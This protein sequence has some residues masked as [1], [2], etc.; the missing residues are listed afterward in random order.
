MARDPIAGPE[1][2]PVSPFPIQLSGK[3]IK[4]FGRG[5][6]E[7]GIPTAN[8]PIEGLDV[9]G[10][11]DVQSGVYFGWVGL[12]M[13]TATDDVSKAASPPG[14]AAS[15]V[16]NELEPRALHSTTKQEV[17]VYPAVLSIGYNLYYK[18]EKRSVEVHVIHKFDSDFYN[19]LLNLSIL[20]FIRTEQDYPSLDALVE[21][22]NFDTEVAKKSVARPAYDKFR[23]DSFLT[24][25]S[26]ANKGSQ[27]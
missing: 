20:G 14:S 18:N 6:K 12:D 5:S 3:V 25:F 13:S 11:R 21:D 1:S 19:A 26:W 22:I 7:L 17:V 4:G 27:R 10:H 15:N 9:G 8:I 24:D 23:G 16:T 2:G